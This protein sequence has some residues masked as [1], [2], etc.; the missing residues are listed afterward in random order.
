[1]LSHSPALEPVAP[2]I[3][4]EVVLSMACPIEL[5]G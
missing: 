1:M 5:Y 3:L 2:Q 4:V